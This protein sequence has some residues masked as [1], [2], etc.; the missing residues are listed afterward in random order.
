[1]A[2]HML[3]RMDKKPEH[4]GGKPGATHRPRLSQRTD[5]GVPQLRDGA[6][7]LEIERCDEVRSIDA[8]RR[9]PPLV[10]E[11]LSLNGRQRFPAG[12]CEQSIDNP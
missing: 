9:H 6:I 12:I 7:D 2:L 4:C 1:M 8:V 5:V 11:G 3:G 10:F